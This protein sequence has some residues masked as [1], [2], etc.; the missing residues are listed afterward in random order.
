LGLAHLSDTRYRM[1]R[2]CDDDESK[3]EPSFAGSVSTFAASAAA[4]CDI[5]AW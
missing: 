4:S 2:L 1:T 5:E 3:R